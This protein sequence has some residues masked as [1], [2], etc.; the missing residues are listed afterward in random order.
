MQINYISAYLF[1]LLQKDAYKNALGF[2][3]DKT[4]I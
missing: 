3:V 2:L 4:Y 1:F